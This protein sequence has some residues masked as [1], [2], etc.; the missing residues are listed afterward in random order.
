M[1][2]WERG[3]VQGAQM[4]G[5]EDESGALRASLLFFPTKE[6]WLFAAGEGRR[7]L[8]GWLIGVLFSDPRGPPREVRSLP[9]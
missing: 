7:G 2:G 1:G 4:F 5:N 9:R 8:L 3:G 6:S